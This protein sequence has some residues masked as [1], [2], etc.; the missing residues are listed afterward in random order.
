MCS[1]T[2][3]PSAL[4]LKAIY[5]EAKGEGFDTKILHKVIRLRAMDPTVR[6]EE[7]SLIDLYMSAVE[8]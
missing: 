8:G 4:D 3:P 5:S 6:S 1:R 7:E 2:S